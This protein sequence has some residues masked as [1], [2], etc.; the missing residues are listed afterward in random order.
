MDKRFYKI[1]NMNEYKEIIMDKRFSFKNMKMEEN[2]EIIMIKRK[3]LNMDK[4]KEIIMDIFSSKITTWMNVKR[5]E[6]YKSGID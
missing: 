2:K 4:Y 5:N 3:N 1:L 6:Y